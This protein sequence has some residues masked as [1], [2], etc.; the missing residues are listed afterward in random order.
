MGNIFT[1]LDK[2]AEEKIREA[3]DRGEFDNLEGKGRPLKLEDDS[4]LPPDI[5]MAYKI[6]KNAGCLPPEVQLRK[7]I[8]ST[9]QLLAGIQDTREKYRQ[10][11]KLNY[12]IMK[13]GMTRKMSPLF[14]ESG[15]YFEKMVDKM[16]TTG[17]DKS[18]R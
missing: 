16:G 9:R 10:M 5:R 1:I 17:T 18:S 6:L 14:E 7:E 8:H 4:H 12:L 13:L 15:E 2:I 3:M 11:Q